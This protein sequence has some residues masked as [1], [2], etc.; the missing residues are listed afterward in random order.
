MQQRWYGGA[1]H[2]VFGLFETLNVCD[3]RLQIMWRQVHR[4]HATR[5]HLRGG[6]LKKFSQLSGGE[7]SCDANESRGRSRAHSAISV[8]CVTGLRLENGLSFRG[9]WVGKRHIGRSKRSG[10]K[11]RFKWS[12][13][14]FLFFG[15][16]LCQLLRN[17][18]IVLVHIL[19]SKPQ[20]KQGD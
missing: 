13:C 2:E 20:S 14:V 15:F 6:M 12:A 11:P 7:L 3:Q 1:R 5:V 4:G 8:A 16:L 10:R 19:A 9:Q 17:S 18:R